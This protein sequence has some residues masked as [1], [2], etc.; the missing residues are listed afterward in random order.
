[1]GVINGSG[2]LMDQGGLE[3]GE[4]KNFSL[5]CTNPLVLQHDGGITAI[6]IMKVKPKMGGKAFYLVDLMSG[7]TDFT[8]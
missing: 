7:L 2:K 4:A 6:L 3:I 5:F 8:T 1:M